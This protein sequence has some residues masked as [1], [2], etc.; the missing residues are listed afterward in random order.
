MSWASP[1]SSRRE[2]FS[3][4]APVLP[5]NKFPGTDMLL[6]PE[7]RSTGEV[8]GTD[9]ELGYAFAKAYI[10]AGMKLPLRGRVLLTVKHTDKRS[11]VSEARQLHQLGYDLV[12][13]EG[14]WRALRSAASRASESTRSTRPAA[15]RRRVEERR[16]RPRA[17]HALRQG[18]ALR[19]LVHPLDGGV[20]GVPCITTLAGIRAMVAALEALHRGPITVRSLQE[21]HA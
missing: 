3:V 15:H 11:I 2:F 10:G 8:M 6:S 9:P 1:E 13:T 21:L 17:Q 5:F 4:K 7:M 16:D 14:T 18:A 20:V 12:G 19:R